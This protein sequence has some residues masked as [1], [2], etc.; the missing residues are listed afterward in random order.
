MR[1]CYG[2][3]L[4][5]DKEITRSMEMTHA[6]DKDKKYIW[7]NNIDEI[8][9]R[10]EELLDEHEELCK[11][12]DCSINKCNDLINKYEASNNYEKLISEYK[13]I[14]S[15]QKYRIHSLGAL[16]HASYLVHS[17]EAIE[18]SSKEAIELLN[19]GGESLNKS[20]RLLNKAIE[21]SNNDVEL[22]KIE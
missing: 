8:F 19:K 22:L 2:M 3:I 6:K 11:K 17:A 14:V 5:S 1:G 16:G 15:L 18:L 13:E 9:D 7:T 12:Y 10:L 4:I 20:N 21:L